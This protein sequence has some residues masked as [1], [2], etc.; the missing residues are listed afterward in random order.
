MADTAQHSAQHGLR[1][2]SISLNTGLRMP[3]S[4]QPNHSASPPG[5]P[6]SA[7]QAEE[8]PVHSGSEESLVILSNSSKHLKARKGPTSRMHKLFPE[9]LD[10]TVL[11]DFS[12]ALQKDILVHGRLYVTER[13]FCFY[14]NIFGWVTKLSIDCKDLVHLRKGK[15][16]LIIPNAITLETATKSYTFTSFI[17]R[18]TAYRCLFKV[19]QNSLLDEPLNAEELLLSSVKGW[20]DNIGNE[21][22]LQNTSTEQMFDFSMSRSRSPLASRS[23][24]S[25]SST[26]DQQNEDEENV[27]D[28][29][30][31][32]SGDEEDMSESSEEED[33]EEGDE[34]DNND[35]TRSINGIGDI[36]ETQ[37][38]D[39]HDRKMH[40]RKKKKKKQDHHHHSH[41]RHTRHSHSRH[42]QHHLQSR[43]QSLPNGRNSTDKEIL[44]VD[45]KRVGARS[46]Q[47]SIAVSDE[48]IE[49]LEDQTQEAVVTPPLTCDFGTTV[50][51]M[52]L[53]CSVEQAGRLLFSYSDMFKELYEERNTSEVHIGEWTPIDHNSD[54]NARELAY[55]LSLDYS[56]GPKSTRGEER[57]VEPVPHKRDQYWIVD[58]DVFTPHVPYGDNFFTKTRVVLSRLTYASC[59][60]QICCEVRYRKSRP[61]AITRQLIESNT[62][63][64][65]VKYYGQLS[66]LLKK[67]AEKAG[68]KLQRKQRSAKPSRTTPPTEH[69]EVEKAK[70]APSSQSQERTI[71]SATEEEAESVMPI[72]TPANS[73]QMPFS[74]DISTLQRLWRQHH[75]SILSIL[76]WTLFVVFSYHLIAAPRVH[77]GWQHLPGDRHSVTPRTMSVQGFQAIRQM[78]EALRLLSQQAKIIAEELDAA[79]QEHDE[80]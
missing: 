45:L 60:V 77:D 22:I 25:L 46:R 41:H 54:I 38:D 69:E 28:D 39:E 24:T 63:T 48:D 50:L 71:P 44:V 2:R 6:N 4:T 21:S 11:D 52:V 64:G 14:A 34:A 43:P 23:G 35:E 55:T 66:R 1:S 12:C 8:T 58:G 57:Q 16:A 17:S 37:I 9:Y 75:V 68:R 13:H 65:L 56:F 5:T 62:N 19:W 49:Q 47:A 18:D 36:K 40:K 29:N 59:R 33:E 79:I 32:S 42:R 51:D 80:F 7:R 3:Q 74:L 31:V 67:H 20:Y 70:E 53:P 27:N 15:T 73:Q 78:S 61:W 10:E 26:G 72:E 76:V 30:D